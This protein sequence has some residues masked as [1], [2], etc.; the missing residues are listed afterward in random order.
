[1]GAR[2]LNRST[3]SVLLTDAGLRLFDRLRP[4]FGQIGGALEDLN[5]QRDRPAGTLRIYATPGAAAVVVAPVWERFVSLGKRMTV[6]VADDF[7]WATLYGNW[8]Q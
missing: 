2:L 4:A 1:M 5:R 7:R 3:R 8:Q 6:V